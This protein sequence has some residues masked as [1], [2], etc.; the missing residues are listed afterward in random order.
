MPI[1]A[2]E[3]SINPCDLLEDSDVSLRHEAEIAP[4]WIFY[5]KARQEKSL[6]RDL[7][8]RDIAFYL[9]LVRRRLLIRSRPVYSHVPLFTGYVFLQCLN[10]DRARALATGRVAQIIPCHDGR[11]LKADLQRIQRLIDSGAPLTV[12]SRLAPSQRVRVRS[13]PMLNLE[14][15]IVKRKNRTRL[16]VWVTMLQQGVSLEIEDCLLEPIG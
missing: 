8:R 10:D 16:L 1:L 3:P 5:T 9:P 2:V 15:T 6:A 12:E 14:G 11:R 7:L 13:G 4:W